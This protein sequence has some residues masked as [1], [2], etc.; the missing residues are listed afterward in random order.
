MGKQSRKHPEPGMAVGKLYSQIS[1]QSLT[2]ASSA[3]F[4]IFSL[5][6]YGSFFFS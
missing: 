3:Y 6:N 4:N 5:T 2:K 1:Q